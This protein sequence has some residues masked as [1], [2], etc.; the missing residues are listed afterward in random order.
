MYGRD[1]RTHTERQRGMNGDTEMQMDI[2]I[3]VLK[4]AEKKQQVQIE[5]EKKMCIQTHRYTCI[6]PC[7]ADGG[8][9]LRPIVLQCPRHAPILRNELKQLEV[10]HVASLRVEHVQP[11]VCDCCHA[12][13]D[14]LKRCAI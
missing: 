1:T 13:V 11:V 9:L 7:C 4:R 2:D 3:Q 5:R 12:L 6:A 10:E 14:L 8:G